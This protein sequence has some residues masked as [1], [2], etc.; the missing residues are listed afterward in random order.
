MSPLALRRYRA[1]RLLRG[2]FEALRSRVVAT[3]QAR[4]GST[5]LDRSDLDACYATAWHGLYGAVLEGQQ[6][7]N[8]VGWLVLVTYRRA[9]EEQRSRARAADREARLGAVAVAERDLAA[10]MDDRM[11]LRRLLEGM[12]LHLDERER[13]AAALCYLHGLSRA[14]AARRMGISQ[15]RMRK[16]MEGR[17]DGRP[18]VAAKV[19]ELV[20]AI[21][22]GRFCEQ[23]ASLMRGLALGVLEPGGERHRLAVM[24]SEDC[25]GCRAYVASLRGLAVALPPAAL[26]TGVLGGLLHATA[27]RLAGAIR[28]GAPS[29]S[30]G[31]STGG[32]WA[33]AGGA[34]AKLVAGSVLAVG[35]GA[36]CA[37]IG[38][39][40]HGAAKVRHRVS[41]AP[42]AVVRA[43]A[44]PA[45]VVPARREG[46]ARTPVSRSTPTKG[47]TATVA[48]AREFGP[49]RGAVAAPASA[50][51]GA[52]ATSASTPSQTAPTSPSPA[53]AGSSTSA[54]GA[55]R[56]FSPG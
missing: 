38:I 42:S 2:E 5:A 55:A 44:A 7:V 52:R 47:P 54:D 22:Q 21:G 25:P 40:G 17:G 18:G 23:H 43:A 27:G 48:A 39:A 11:R 50:T 24:H 3:V 14:Q 12:R 49:E 45:S 20:A 30:G 26:P 37:A 16:L 28:G 46:T 9:V 19:G 29:S 31:G 35:V 1:E 8:P 15:T 36:G 56:E 41:A 10:E 51:A 34:P 33:L 4:L 53:P 32:G 6:I 13:Q